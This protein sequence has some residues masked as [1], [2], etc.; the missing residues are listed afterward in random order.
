ML[1]EGMYMK[2]HDSVRYE[3]LARVQAFGDSHTDTFPGGDNP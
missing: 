3:M 1:V 2:R